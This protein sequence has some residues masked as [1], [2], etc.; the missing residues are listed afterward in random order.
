MANV[1]MTLLLQFH[2]LGIYTI[3]LNSSK[4]KWNLEAKSLTLKYELLACNSQQTN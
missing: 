4:E 1:G 3:L 2:V